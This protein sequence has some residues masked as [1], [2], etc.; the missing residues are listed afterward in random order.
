MMEHKMSVMGFALKLLGLRSHGCVEL[1]KKLLKK[2]YNVES[3][4][5]VI[6]KLKRQ[7]VLDDT[8]FG[9]E[10]I[11]SRS[12]RKPAGKL[13]IRAE[14]RNKGVSETII[15]D[16]LK[17]YDG[18]ELCRRAAEKK[19]GSLHGSTEIKKKKLEVFLHNRGF[20]WQDIQI[21]LKGFFQ[22]GSDFENFT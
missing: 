8:Q 14:L 15:V 13:K 2:G 11:R 16:L 17:E 7:G 21:V 1:E 10:L 18:T 20:E 22:E 6:E 9:A 3:V 5:E 12:R 19:I 4:A